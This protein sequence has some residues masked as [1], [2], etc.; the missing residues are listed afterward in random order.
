VRWRKL[1]VSHAID[2]TVNCPLS[3]KNRVSTHSGS[4]PARDDR[5]T[6][7]QVETVDDKVYIVDNLRLIKQQTSQARAPRDASFDPRA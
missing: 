5:T 2:L 6:S 4:A 3:G 7:G 1:V